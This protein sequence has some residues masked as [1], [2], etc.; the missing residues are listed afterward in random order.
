[1]VVSGAPEKRANHAEKVCDMALDMTYGITGLKDP[2]TGDS[3]AIR[4]GKGLTK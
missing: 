1:M 4:I 3:I 2:S